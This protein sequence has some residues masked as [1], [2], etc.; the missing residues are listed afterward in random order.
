[1]SNNIRYFSNYFNQ[2][3]TWIRGEEKSFNSPKMARRSE[4]LWL[5]LP[6]QNPLRIE[7]C[8]KETFTLERGIVKIS[9]RGEGVGWEMSLHTPRVP[10]WL[11]CMLPTKRKN[12]LRMNVRS[13]LPPP[14][15]PRHCYNCLSYFFSN[16]EFYWPF[17]SE[18]LLLNY[19]ALTTVVQSKSDELWNLVVK[20]SL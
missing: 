12:N 16:N 18:L 6:Q 1:M 2:Q 5:T 8:T 3:S 10:T 13:T 7:T 15:R 9:K 11:R 14:F 20:Y 4:Y 17:V 19:W